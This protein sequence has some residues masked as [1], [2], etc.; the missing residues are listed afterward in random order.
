MLGAQVSYHQGR[1]NC[2]IVEFSLISAPFLYSPLALSE[3][4]LPGV[5]SRGLGLF[6]LASP[7]GM[8]DLSSLT[9]D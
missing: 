2:G 5:V 9:R 6:F 1:W 4:S 8:Q 3:F 7:C